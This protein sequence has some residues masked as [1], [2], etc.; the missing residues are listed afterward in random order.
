MKTRQAV[1][2]GPRQVEIREKVIELS[3]DHI[4][5]QMQGTGMC[6]SEL[7]PW[8]GEKPQYPMVLG[9]EGWGVVVDK[10]R[11]VSARIQVGDRVSGLPL[12]CCADY[13]TQPEWC[14]MKLRADLD[15]QCVLG[16]PYYCVN[17]VVRAA[18]PEVGDC[19]VL[20][21]LGPMGQWALQALAS[22]NLHSVIAIDV[23]E[24]KL[25]M[26]RSYG[27]T[28][29]I[30][31]K[32]V[33]A[34]VAVREITG[35]RMA[36]VIVEGTG[37]KPGMDLAVNLLRRG[38]R[39]RLVVMSF[40]KGPI[41]IDIARLCGVSAEVVHAHPG[42]TADKPDHCRRTEIMINRGVFKSDHLISHS[43]RLEETAQGYAA[44]ENR[45]EGFVKGIVVP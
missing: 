1:L 44:L 21:G 10:G 31:S 20:V 5:V 2:V 41:E 19:V 33:D 45:A 7:P 29:A 4:L 14:T 38:P 34:V 28:H 12:N 30:H 40:F 23:D 32:H 24:A 6:T 16:E 36:D 37:A 39:P 9:H 3:A 42:I 8:S 43:F 27:A 26:A 17:N 13:F 25:A 15:Q 18:H 11:D 35:G 22:P